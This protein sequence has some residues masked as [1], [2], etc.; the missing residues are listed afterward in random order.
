M[1]PSNWVVKTTFRH[2]TN[3]CLELLRHAW[4][5]L[6]YTHYTGIVLKEHSRGWNWPFWPGIGEFWP[7]LGG[8]PPIYR[9]SILADL[10]W[11]QRGQK[12]VKNG[13]KSAD[14]RT[15]TMPDYILQ[16]TDPDRGI[17]GWSER[18]KIKQNMLVGSCRRKKK[19][20]RK[21]PW[22]LFNFWWF[23]PKKYAIAGN[24]YCMLEEKIK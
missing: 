3:P 10:Y 23:S 20:K 4:M 21:I 1:W 14:G 22:I 9:S 6:G 2:R 12:S 18:K 17:P 15:K 19:N 8:L 11:S 7:F 5:S 13:R 16:L 24:I